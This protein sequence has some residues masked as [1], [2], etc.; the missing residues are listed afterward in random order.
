MRF[1]YAVAIGQNRAVEILQPRVA[2]NDEHIAAKHMAFDRAVRCGHFDLLS[3]ASYAQSWASKLAFKNAGGP[4]VEQGTKHD[5]PIQ[6]SVA[7]GHLNIFKWLL[8]RL[9]TSP[10]IETLDAY[11]VSTWLGHA[12]YGGHR[13][14]AEYL[15]HRFGSK[16][17]R[18]RF[19][20]IWFFGLVTACPGCKALAD[21]AAATGVQPDYV[22]RVKFLV[23]AISDH[24]VPA[25]TLAAFIADMPADQ[26]TPLR[27][28]LP[29]QSFAAMA[30]LRDAGLLDALSYST[31][32]LTEAV[33]TG[34]VDLVR[35]ALD[36]MA[37]RLQ[38]IDLQDALTSAAIINH[39]EMT[40]LCLLFTSP[41]PRD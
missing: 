12:A 41:S 38:V 23:R 24:R 37:P 14:M 31:S 15:L 26:R 3:S 21:A 17:V 25:S 39:A 18:K 1:I 6:A 13:E 32:D 29:P 36:V 33:R 11:T 9:D 34:D 27:S 35:L 5:E 16:I 7:Y 19:H 10:E 40:E 28:L 22:A 2:H 20:G 8:H 4:D 30:V